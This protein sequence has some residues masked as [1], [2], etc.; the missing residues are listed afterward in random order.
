MTATRSS[1]R[2]A[3]PA[4]SRLFSVAHLPRTGLEASGDDAGFAGAL[5]ELKVGQQLRRG[6]VSQRDIALQA[7]I[8]D[9][10]QLGGDAAVEFRDGN[11]PFL[12]T[13]DQ[14]G[15]R[16]VGAEGRLTRSA[17]HKK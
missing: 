6:L 3:A 11:D 9:V 16:A 5:P 10:A 14:A 1:S 17:T 8:H 12:G 13:F 4:S 7:S 15:Q 2:T